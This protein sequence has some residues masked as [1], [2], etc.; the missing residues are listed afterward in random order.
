MHAEKLGVMAIVMGKVDRLHNSPEGSL[1]TLSGVGHKVR[2]DRLILAWI[3]TF[4]S[5]ATC[6]VILGGYVRLS[7]S[8]LSIVEWNPIHGVVPPLSQQAWEE[9]FAKYKTSPEFL[10]VNF[11]ISIEKFKE[12]YLLEWVHR[13]LAR[14]AGLVFALPFFLFV[15]LKIIRFKDIKP[16]VIIGLLFL[17]QAVMGWV[18]VSTGLKDRP[19]VSHY[20]LAAHLS[21]AFILIGLSLWTALNI[22]YQA[23]SFGHWTRSSRLFFLLISILFVEILYGAFTAGLKAGHISD[24][25]PLMYGQFVPLGLLSQSESVLANFVESPITVVFV[26]RWLSFGFLLTAISF[27]WTSRN[28]KFEPGLKRGLRFLILLTLFQIFLGVMV[29]I[30]HVDVVLALSHQ[31]NAILL[32]ATSIFVLHRLK[33]A[34]L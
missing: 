1:S 19:A 4:I 10:K 11:A 12:I 18:M 30:S 16:Y 6:L 33:A 3:F 25:W 2:F 15:A 9:E 29:T 34:E 5:L 27:F 13:L 7:R 22:I 32:F 21:F 31:A 14:V 26:H 28:E 20:A 24:T 17:V 8:G 23:R